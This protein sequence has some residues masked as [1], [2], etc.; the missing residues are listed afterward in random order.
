M[1]RYSRSVT[2]SSLQ[3]CR[4]EFR[5]NNLCFDSMYRS[6]WAHSRHHWLEIMKFWSSKCK[7]V[8]KRRCQTR[9]LEVRMAMVIEYDYYWMCEYG[10]SLVLFLMIR[11]WHGDAGCFPP[12]ASCRCIWLNEWGMYFVSP[13]T[14]RRDWP[15]T[16]R[17]GLLRLLRC[18]LSW[19][20]AE[21]WWLGIWGRPGRALLPKDRPDFRISLIGYID[22]GVL[23]GFRNTSHVF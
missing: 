18:P 11:Q 20:Q 19:S 6:G 7:W 21:L 13:S 16:N 8:Q 9:S 3:S 5:L 17:M 1:R 2:R 14:F 12:D 15:R 22:I 10:E 4:F 23:L